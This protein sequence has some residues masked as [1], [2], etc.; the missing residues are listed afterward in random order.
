MEAAEVEPPEGG[1]NTEA[2]AEPA[3]LAERTLEVATFSG[4]GNEIQPQPK[5]ICKQYDPPQP[6]D[7]RRVS[8][9]TTKGQRPFRYSPTNY[10]LYILF[11]LCCLDTVV[12]A[13]SFPLWN[14]EIT[15]EQPIINGSILWHP[16]ERAIF[17]KEYQFLTLVYKVLPPR[18]S[19]GK[20]LCGR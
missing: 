19:D 11:I 17:V 6:S 20:L 14:K 10:C 7:T 3:P 13:A 8:S 12:D 4:Q 16:W 5:P 18:T 2:T 9:R 15:K 1:Y